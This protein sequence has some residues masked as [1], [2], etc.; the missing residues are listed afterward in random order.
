MNYRNLFNKAKEL[1]GKR[2][3]AIKI[4]AGVLLAAVTAYI[5]APSVR[6][7]FSI[8]AAD[9]KL[10][11]YSVKT[12]QKKVAIS[13]D[14]AWG[15]DDTD[16]LLK[17]LSDNGVKSTFFLCGY[18]VEKYPEEVKKIHAAGHDIG[19]HSATHP[20]GASLT[21][22][23]N[24]SEIMKAHEKVKNLLGIDMNLYRPPFG[25][26]N[27]T[28]IE[29]AEQCGYYPVQWDVDSLD[30]KNYGVEHEV[31]RVLNNK[32]LGNGSI[33]LFHNDADYTPAALDKIIKGL[34]GKGYEIVPISEL[35]IK[36]N[37]HIDPTG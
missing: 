19:N 16:T 15:A 30:W 24:K 7:V 20:H 3:K 34:K 21:L 1:F 10:P 29:A 14:A 2:E 17:I 26:Y 27:N 6:A 37:Y 25:E 22:E 18:W 13:F 33:V 5:S 11:I 35:I 31:D 12:D 4:T 28:V 32:N 8:A 9:R 36:E 23:Q